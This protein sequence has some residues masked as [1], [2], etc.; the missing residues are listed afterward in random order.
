M[1]ASARQLSDPTKATTTAP[2]SSNM[3][4]IDHNERRVRS[5]A[6]TSFYVAKKLVRDV[7][8]KMGYEIRRAQ[9]AQSGAAT[10]TQ[11][12]RLLSFLKINCTFDVGANVGQFA[13]HLRHSGYTGRIISFEPLA[14]AWEKLSF[15]SANDDAW[16]VHPRCAIG[17]REALVEINVAGNS[18]SSSLL[19]MHEQHYRSAPES[20]YIGQQKAKLIRLSSVFG[21]YARPQD[22]VLV[23]IDT[24]GYE[25]QV[26]D[27]CDEILDKV[28][29]IYIELSLTP[30]Y[31][32]EELWRYFVDRLEEQGFNIW[33]VQPAFSDP[34][35]GRTLQ[36]DV[37][38]VRE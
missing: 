33:N 25:K 32:G 37:L 1:M 35:S 17:E 38:F 23:K 10:Q 36:I 34:D 24:Q 26:L 28:R 9:P 20:Q 6:K 18:Q 29:A 11:L 27:G 31:A 19:N 3:E 22:N 2:R 30:L 12:G 14:D 7:V 8:K 13:D 15:A 21:R 16:I 5:R 4:N